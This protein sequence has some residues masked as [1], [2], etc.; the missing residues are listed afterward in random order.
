MALSLGLLSAAAASASWTHGAPASLY[1]LFATQAN[2]TSAR[3]NYANEYPTN[4]GAL[5]K[6]G[7]MPWQTEPALN[8]WVTA[9]YPGVLWK[10]ANRSLAAGDAAGAAWWVSQGNAYNAHLIDNENNTG[11]H[12]VGFMT[13]PAFGQQLSLTNNKTAAAIL[14]RTAGSLAYR[15][16]PIVGAFESWG[17]LNPTNHRFEVSPQQHLVLSRNPSAISGPGTETTQ[18]KWTRH[19][20]AWDFYTALSTRHAAVRERAATRTRASATCRAP[21]TAHAHRQ[22][23]ARAVEHTRCHPLSPPSSPRR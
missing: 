18:H 5:T 3:L 8:N 6:A 10:L 2:A 12:D 17:P 16:S 21:P 14:A 11:T 15:F 19:Y 22:P 20:L 13:V 23:R 7:F 4:G 9:F 1:E